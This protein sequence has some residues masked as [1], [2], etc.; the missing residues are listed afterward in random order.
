MQHQQLRSDRERLLDTH[1]LEKGLQLGRHDAA[2]GRELVG[3]DRSGADGPGGAEA[4][5]LCD[6]P[7]RHTDH[8]SN[9]QRDTDDTPHPRKDL[10]PNIKRLV[11]DQN[12]IAV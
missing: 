4:E 8:E 3:D 2:Y 6:A 10:P 9:R 5:K 12:C 1:V 7:D 11:A